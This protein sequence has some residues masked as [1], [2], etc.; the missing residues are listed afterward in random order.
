VNYPH[1]IAHRGGGSL[2]PEN[3]LAGI[4]LAAR[5]GRRGV[6][7]DVMLSRDG[8][9]VLIHDETVDRTTDGSGAVAALTLAELRRLDA[10][11]EPVPTLAEAL[12][13]CHTLGLWLN[14]EIKPGRGR[15]AAT[16][17]LAARLLAARWPGAGIVSSFSETALAAA[18]SVAPKLD[19]ALLVDEPPADWR[20]RLERLGCR[21]LHC[22]AEHFRPELAA[23]G[24]PVACYT[25][26]DRKQ[27]DALLAAGAVAVFTDRPD[28]WQPDE[29]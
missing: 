1:V 22:R 17:E 13:L 15:E 23:T 4:M 19:Y 16:G 21:A 11:G 27:A 7:F 25:V 26:N 20:Q 12:D 5:L 29:G 6:E 8:I 10:G 28:L 24:T 14:A 9:P 2:A 3:T 18:R